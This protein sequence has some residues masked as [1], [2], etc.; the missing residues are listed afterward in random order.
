MIISFN[1]PLKGKKDCVIKEAV[2]NK[3]LDIVLPLFWA[4]STIK[5]VAW[6]PD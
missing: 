3:N 2:A 1:L 4:N 5:Y 6:C